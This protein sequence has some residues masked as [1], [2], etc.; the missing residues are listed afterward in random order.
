VVSSGGVIRIRGGTGVERC[1]VLGD[2]ARGQARLGRAEGP[3]TPARPP[4]RAELLRRE[5]HRCD[6]QEVVD[7][8]LGH[9][10]VDAARR[11]AVRH[12]GSGL[13]ETLEAEAPEPHAGVDVL[14]AVSGE[15]PIKAAGS[16]GIA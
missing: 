6:P 11:K 3:R 9:C 5:V 16:G 13:D 14:P 1:P 12:D 2:L 8:I 10:D 7:G 15:A 4:E